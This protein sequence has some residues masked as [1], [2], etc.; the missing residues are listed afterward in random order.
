MY[1]SYVKTPGYIAAIAAE[2]TPPPIEFGHYSFDFAQQVHLPSD[3]LQP[4]LIYFLT[5]RKCAHFGVCCEA[6]PLKVRT[7]QLHVS[8]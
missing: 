4:G 7:Q 2:A 6:I 3:P 1:Q 5:P 8:K